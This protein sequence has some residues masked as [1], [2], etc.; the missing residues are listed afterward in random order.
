MQTNV[1][2][3]PLSISQFNSQDPRSCGICLASMAPSLMCTYRWTTTTGGHVALLTSNILDLAAKVR[4][5]LACHCCILVYHSAP[6]WPQWF[7]VIMT[8]HGSDLHTCICHDCWCDVCVH[9]LFYWG[10]LYAP[11]IFYIKLMYQNI[12]I[13]INI[14]FRI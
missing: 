7:R 8:G 2:H 4:L 3:V 5:P 6:I 13:S 14:T 1:H 11:C 9:I 12:Y 10:E